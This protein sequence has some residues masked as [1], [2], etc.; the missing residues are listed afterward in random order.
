M[1]YEVAREK[2]AYYGVDTEAA[3]NRVAEI[4]ISIN[5]WQGD[6]VRGFEDPDR[7]L[8][9]GIMATGN[10]PGRARTVDELRDDF[11]VAAKLIP[12]A[13]RINL[14]A[15]Y[16]DNGGARVERNEITPQHFDS[17]IDWVRV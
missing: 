15:I 1:S 5:C 4:P 11:D 16:L 3:I 10:Y 12:G 8:S 13:K 17:W 6:D 7:A 9:G 14:H 2:Y